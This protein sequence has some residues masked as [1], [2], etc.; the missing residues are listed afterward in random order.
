MAGVA[1][2]VHTTDDTAIICCH[3]WFCRPSPQPGSMGHVTGVNRSDRRGFQ[4]WQ[5][6]PG[7]SGGSLWVV[8]DAHR[9]GVLPSTWPGPPFAGTRIRWYRC[10]SARCAPGW[11]D[12]VGPGRAGSVP[13]SGS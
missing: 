13:C 8:G 11:G 4:S 12:R 7:R 9:M 1:V 3:A 10:P 5:E 6:H 2:S